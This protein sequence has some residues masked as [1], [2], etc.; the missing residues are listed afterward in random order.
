M[1]K[2]YAL[3]YVNNDWIECISDSLSKGN[4]EKLPP[5]RM[6]ALVITHTL[7]SYLSLGDQLKLGCEENFNELK[8]GLRGDPKIDYGYC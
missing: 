1:S 8:R 3:R 7:F 5:L 6:Q 4:C 2:N